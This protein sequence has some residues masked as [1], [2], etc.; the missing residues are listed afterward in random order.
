MGRT[1][2]IQATSVRFVGKAFYAG[3]SDGREVSI[4][5]ESVPWLHWLLTAS[6]EQRAQWTT[7]P[8]GYALY[9]DSLDD[10]V[11]IGRLLSRAP[12]G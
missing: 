3:L 6:D 7:E 11:E 5:L 9:W 12:L 8:G 1:D 4:P 10:G 2:S